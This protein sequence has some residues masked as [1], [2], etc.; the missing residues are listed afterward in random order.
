LIKFT[1][2]ITE[3]IFIGDLNDLRFGR[4]VSGFYLICYIYLYSG[5]F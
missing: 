3:P 1:K 4:S 5:D 2:S